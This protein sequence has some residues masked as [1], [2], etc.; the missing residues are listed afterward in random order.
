MFLTIRHIWGLYR[1]ALTLRRHH[2]IV[3][4]SA[5]PVVPPALPRLLRLTTFFIPRKSGLPAS[6]GARLALALAQMGPAYIKL[7]Q[8]LATRPDVIGRPLAEG[9]LT[10]QD[11]LPP[12]AWSKAKAIMESELGG[13]LSDHFSDFDQ[14]AIAAASIAQVHKATTNEGRKVAVKVRRPDI[15]GRFKRD[16]SLFSWI[17]K[18]AE[19]HSKQAQRL[20]L[21]DVA[22]TV[23]DSTLKEMDFR[24]EAASNAELSA[25]MAGE[26]GYRIP[27]VDWDRTFEKMMTIEWVDGIRF[28]DRDALIAAGYDM[29]SLSQKI[30][31]IFLKQAMRD[32]FFH[33]DLHQGNLIVEEGGTICAID[34]GIMGRI[35]KKEQ[36]FLAE[37]LWGFIRRDYVKVAEVHFDAGYIPR[38]ENLHEFAE[39][40]KAIAD[41]IMDLPVEEISAGK[42]LA[43]LF[44]TTER[45]SMQ[46]Q[47]QLILLQRTMVMAEGMALHLNPQSNMWDISRPILENWM[48]DNLSPEIQLADFI[49]SLPRL[50]SR[51]PKMI[52]RLGN[53][54]DYDDKTP[55]APVIIQ[56]KT[57]GWIVFALGL[58]AGAAVMRIFL[59]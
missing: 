39:A 46:T 48:K 54:Y 55:A 56:Q 47:P 23:E 10:L 12:F 32:G 37:I 16:L 25:N 11:S 9:L 22:R 40:L 31:Q 29:D 43:Q 4:L 30:V 34:F 50:L 49:N 45:F 15:M 21:N 38:G 59:Y 7:G 27:E 26:A 24:T 2:A 14:T 18:L 19:S 58:I 1:L 6:P 17:A 8:T 41:P 36:R 57:S 28:T 53:D 44:S 42:L 52:D 51:L 33:A 35:N 3:S 5:M 20:R 13:P